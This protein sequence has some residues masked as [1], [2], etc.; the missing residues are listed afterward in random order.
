MGT[1]I[2]RKKNC[3][4]KRKTASGEVSSSDFSAE[5]PT[6]MQRDNDAELKD[7]N[8]LDKVKWNKLKKKDNF[9]RN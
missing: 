6:D 5:E 4:R 2:V 8:M 3:G 7:L 9:H 1:S